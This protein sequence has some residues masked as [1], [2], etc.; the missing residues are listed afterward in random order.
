MALFDVIRYPVDNIFNDDQINAVPVWIAVPW[1]KECFEMLGT[2]VPWDDE[3]ALRTE[4]VV[5]YIRRALLTF[6][7]N[8]IRKSRYDNNTLVTDMMALAFRKK[9]IDKIRDA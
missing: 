7:T 3:L 8:E 1:A 6:M 5:L 4:D 2:E 9:L